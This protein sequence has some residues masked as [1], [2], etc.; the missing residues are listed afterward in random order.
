EITAQL[1]AFTKTNKIVLNGAPFV[2]YTSTGRQGA[3]MQFAVCVPIKEEIFTMPGSEYEGGRLEGFR[4]L[5]TTLKGYYSHLK[6]A[7]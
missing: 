6:K 1:T 5:K 4:A 3:E 7:W 2:I